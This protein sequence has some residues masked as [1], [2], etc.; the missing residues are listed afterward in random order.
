MSAALSGGSS[1]RL[2]KLS[3]NAIEHV[4]KADAQAI[5]A[6]A[7]KLLSSDGPLTVRFFIDDCA[8]APDRPA[9][10]SFV[11]PALSPTG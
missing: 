3:A 7:E 9:S 5:Q 11:Q 4:R 10:G 1:T 6:A 2:A 8:L